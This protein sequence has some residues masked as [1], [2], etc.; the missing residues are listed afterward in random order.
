MH[1]LVRSCAVGSPS[2]YTCSGF[3]VWQFVFLFAAKC[4][5]TFLLKN[6]WVHDECYRRLLNKKGRTCHS[7]SDIDF[8][9]TTVGGSTIGICFQ[10]EKKAWLSDKPTKKGNRSVLWVTQKLALGSRG[11]GQVWYFSCRCISPVQ[12]C[13]KSRVQLPNSHSILS[14]SR[15]VR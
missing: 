8:L 11:L 4:F 7:Y 14:S 13:I 1:S 3:Q 5:T 2:D 6:G 15:S 12:Q 9:L 10:C